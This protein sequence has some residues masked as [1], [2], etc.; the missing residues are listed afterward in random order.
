MQTG[1]DY[2][3]FIQMYGIPCLDIRYLY[4]KVK[5]YAGYRAKQ[6]RCQLRLCLLKLQ[7]VFLLPTTAVNGG[8]ADY[9][10]RELTIVSIRKCLFLDQRQHLILQ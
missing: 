6:K 7:A 5:V 9:E 8:R 3:P 1:S 10:C 4:D 2:K